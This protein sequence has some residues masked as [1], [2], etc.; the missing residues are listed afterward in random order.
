MMATPAQTDTIPRN[1][2]AG[3]HRNR[4]RTLSRSRHDRHV[5]FDAPGGIGPISAAA[6]AGCVDIA[7]R[8][9]RYPPLIARFSESRGLTDRLWGGPGAE[10]RVRAPNRRPRIPS[11]A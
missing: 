9:I 11:G 8:R 6:R 2:I 5:I 1:A 3:H 4:P 10:F 7:Q